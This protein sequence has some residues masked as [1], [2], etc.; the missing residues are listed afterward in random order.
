MHYNYSY[1]RMFNIYWSLTNVTDRNY[2]NSLSIAKFKLNSP[3]VQIS[4]MK[5]NFIAPESVNLLTK[6]N[7]KRL[8]QSTIIQVTM[9]GKA[10]ITT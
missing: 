1:V 9:H 4:I 5:I 10:L 3:A 2:C 6:Q 7:F 8:S